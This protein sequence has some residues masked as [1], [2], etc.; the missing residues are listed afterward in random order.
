[1]VVDY[2]LTQHYESHL[3]RNGLYR[4][5]GNWGKK[6]TKIINGTQPKAQ[7]QTPQ[8]G[9]G[10][11]VSR[12]R[13]YHCSTL[14]NRNSNLSMCG[15]FWKKMLP[16][17]DNRDSELMPTPTEIYDLNVSKV[18]LR[19]WPFRTPTSIFGTKELYNPGWLPSPRVNW[20]LDR[21][22]SLDL[23]AVE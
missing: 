13:H 2:H 21:R 23:N 22:E 7:A 11:S 4:G 20:A 5:D 6:K 14:I 10:D 8:A 9:T 18:A 19:I 16:P 15:T 12:F 3:P 17:P 1:M